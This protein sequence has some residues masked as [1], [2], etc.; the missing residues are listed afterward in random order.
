M[1]LFM[2]WSETFKVVVAKLQGELFLL[3]KF[4]FCLCVLL[5]LAKQALYLLNHISNHFCFR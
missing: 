1:F 5:G 3:V 2:K 4:V